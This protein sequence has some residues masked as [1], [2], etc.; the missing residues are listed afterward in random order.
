MS[1]AY[2]VYRLRDKPSSGINMES[3]REFISLY[4]EKHDFLGEKT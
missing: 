3:I 4:T 2:H 1:K